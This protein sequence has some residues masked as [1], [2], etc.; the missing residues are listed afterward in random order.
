VIRDA[1][2]IDAEALVALSA[3]ISR[4]HRKLIK[5]TGRK[6][7]LEIVVTDPRPRRTALGTRPYLKCRVLPE[8]VVLLSDIT[9]EDLPCG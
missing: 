4:A 6:Y 5:K 9:G 8:T 2:V 1:F 7:H 3:S